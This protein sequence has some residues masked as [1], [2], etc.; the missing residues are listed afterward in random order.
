MAN[1]KSRY[2]EMERYMTYTIIADGILFILYLIVAGLGV[3]W[4]K[5]VAAVLA[6]VLSVLILGYLYMTKE[7]LNRR[8]LWMSTAAAAVA[9]CVLF[10]LI[11]NFPSP[12]YELPEQDTSVTAQK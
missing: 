1:K 7:L 9:I 10:S 2:Q 11:F 4:L 5:V 3:V 8:S 6:I 12:K